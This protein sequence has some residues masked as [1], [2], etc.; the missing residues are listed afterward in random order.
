MGG[1]LDGH[2]AGDL[3][4]GSE[5]R[6]RA[7]GEFDRL[8]GDGGDALGEQGVGEGLLGGEVEV[9]EEEEV[10]AEEGIFGG[11]GLLDF[12]DEVGGAPDVGGVGEQG[13]A[14]GEIFSVGEAAAVAGVG[15]DEEAVAGGDEGVDAA[16]GEGNPVLLVLDLFRDSNDHL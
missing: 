12:E 3:A 6:E 4:H 1:D 5:E 16:G 15:L 13:G 14:G 9:G 11:E 2:L 10:G 8:V 7:V